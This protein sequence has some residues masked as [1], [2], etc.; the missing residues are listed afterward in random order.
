[1]D[2]K[3]MVDSSCQTT[4]TFVWKKFAD[5]LER[6]YSRKRKAQIY[7]VQS[8]IFS[9]DLPDVTVTISYDHPVLDYTSEHWCGASLEENVYENP[10][11][12]ENYPWEVTN[13]TWNNFQNMCKTLTQE[14]LQS[15]KDNREK[16][17]R[18]EIEE[19][20]SNPYKRRRYVMT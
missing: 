2:T 10:Y 11:A 20:D 12:A 15:L 3:T 1:M 18:E 6:T 17:I 4:Y 14:E 7:D 9:G 19:Y 13:Q 5:K 8:D 16:R